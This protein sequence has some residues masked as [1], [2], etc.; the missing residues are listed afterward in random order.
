MQISSGRYRARAKTPE[1]ARR[2]GHYHESVVPQER[3]P[4]TIKTAGVEFDSHVYDA[5]VDVRR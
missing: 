3:S 1:D 2:I 4:M 5:E